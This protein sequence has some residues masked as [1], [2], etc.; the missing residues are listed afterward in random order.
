MKNILGH[1]W[2]Y[3]RSYENN[4]CS[5]CEIIVFES[6]D[7]NIYIANSWRGEKYYGMNNILL[8]ITCDEVMI[9]NLLE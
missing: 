8:E 2:K 4:I 7:G 9:K 6:N 1:V 3:D 5:R